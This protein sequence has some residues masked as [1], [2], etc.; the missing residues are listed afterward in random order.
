MCG[1]AGYL[2][3]DGKPASIIEL[4]A[5]VDSI[6]H[7][8]PDGEGHF[9]DGE[10]AIGHRRL[11]IV[12][13]SSL[14]NQPMQSKDRNFVLSYNG[15]LYNYKSIKVEL[16]ARGYEFFSESDTEVV[17]NALA[18]W[19]REALKKF[20]GMFSLAFWNRKEK[21]LLL[22]RDRFGVKPLYIFQSENNL[23]F[24]SEVKA[25]KQ[26]LDNQI[27]LNKSALI[28]YMTFQNYFSN[29][30]LFANITTL[31]NGS[32][33]QISKDGGCESDSYWDFNFFD[34]NFSLSEADAENE[35]ENLFSAAVNRQLIGDV[36]FS[37]YLSGGVDSG[38]IT[39]VASSQIQNLRTFTVGFDL[40]SAS[41]LELGFDE[42]KNAELMSYIFKTEHYEM[43]LKAGD[44]EKC[45]KNLIWHMEEPR[46][47]QSYPNYY[48]ANLAS[49]FGKV[50]LS[51]T[52]GD[53][54]F[55]GY[56]WRYEK[57]LDCKNFDDFIDRYYLYWQRLLPRNTKEK[58]F[59]PINE[60]LEK[61]STRD[62]FTN[63]FS[64]LDNSQKNSENFLGLA[65]YFECKTFLQGLLTIEDKLSMAHSLENRV[66]FLDNELVDFAS[67][68]PA[69]F[70]L[71]R[72]GEN[73]NVPKY[74]PSFQTD[75]FKKTNDGKILLRAVMN[76][77]VPPSIANGQKKGF[78][79]PDASWYRGESVEYCR[80]VLFSRNA[81]IYDFLDRKTTLGLVEE[82]LSG[83][84]N[85][86]LLLW[87][88]L[89]V[90]TWC[91]VFT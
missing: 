30:T 18:E 21:V 41:G 48:A 58:L 44:M 75:K 6:A 24:A 72:M 59:A 83:E 82:H 91:Q 36:L 71:G 7:R 78:S 88:L 27:E 85:R 5:M 49:K 67:K 16:Q 89:C 23:I 37:S 12:D 40:N 34:E 38:S 10:F 2:N 61:T 52:G 81:K 60:T 31:P 14:G 90:E 45:M 13:L 76:K 11:S 17:L 20:D 50:V 46:V 68:L 86:R 8:G 51:G 66:P 39:A 84:Q 19:G 1:I 9:I 15:E 22:A 28:E 33:L 63:V 64:K 4:K 65:M 55:G 3:L 62:I 35:L 79:A 80:D 54:I 42:R 25:I 47:G 32:W 74:N 69:R 77:F 43:V 57:I 70:K 26:I 53:E 56:P 29:Q 73:K 87:S